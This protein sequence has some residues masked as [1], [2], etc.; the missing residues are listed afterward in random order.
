MNVYEL[1]TSKMLERLEAGVI[2]WRKCGTSG[3]AKSLAHKICV[4]LG[5]SVNITPAHHGVYKHEEF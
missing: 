1:I 4:M 3:P 2:P 5:P